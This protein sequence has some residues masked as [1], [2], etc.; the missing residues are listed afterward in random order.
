[1]G[2]TW[3]APVNAIPGGWQV[4]GIVTLSKGL[5]LRFNVPRNTR[6]AFGGRQRP[7]S[8]GVNADLGDRKT[9][10][11]WFDTSQFTLPVQITFGNPARNHPNPRGD[12]L[13]HLDAS[14]FK[15][16][17]L[18]ERMKIQFRGEA[19]NVAIHPLFSDPSAT[20]TSGT[21][22]LV[23]NRENSPRQIQLSLKL[24]F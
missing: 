17:T 18:K 10:N 20:L 3:N 12:S 11:R 5:P 23:T 19:F 2:Q 15:T 6:L 1:M 4:N 24:L 8:T 16:F 13:Q 21:F 22:G 9:I 7:D 14:I